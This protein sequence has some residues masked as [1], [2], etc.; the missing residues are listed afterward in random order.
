M[1]ANW[2]LFMILSPALIVSVKLLGY[3]QRRLLFSRVLRRTT[4]HAV[5]PRNATEISYCSAKRIR[6]ILRAVEGWWDE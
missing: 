1:T 4:D 6:Q 2:F 5:G 3:N